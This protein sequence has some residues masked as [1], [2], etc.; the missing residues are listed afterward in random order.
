[1]DVVLFSFRNANDVRL[2]D[3]RWCS[4]RSL[5]SGADR[6][7]ASSC[8]VACSYTDRNELK[9]IWDAGQSQ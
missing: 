9:R 6:V 4:A 5:G 2:F 7:A 8:V 1:M 3:P